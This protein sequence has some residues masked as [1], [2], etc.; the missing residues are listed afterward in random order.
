MQ[1][2]VRD[3]SRYLN[4]F[5][6]TVTRWIKQR[7]LP[8]QYVGGQFRFNR[9]EVLEWATANKVKVSLELF[10]NLDSDQDSVPSLVAAL[11]AGGIFY[12]LHGSDKANTLRALVQ[13]LP[14]PEGMDREL[15][16]R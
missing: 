10:D 13:V 9:A 11:E 4:V 16:L 3:V 2:T 14:L 15:L 1:L 6:S 7:G 12:K 8:S 5:E